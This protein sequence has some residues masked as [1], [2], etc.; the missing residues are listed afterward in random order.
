MVNA[1]HFQTQNAVNGPAVPPVDDKVKRYN[2]N[3]TSTISILIPASDEPL[4]GKRLALL[5]ALKDGM[6]VEQYLETAKKLK[7]NSFGKT[8]AIDLLVIMKTKK[9]VAVKSAPKKSKSEAVAA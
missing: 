6:T 8:S 5:K 2:P 9:I 1:M 4:K 7:A 3:M